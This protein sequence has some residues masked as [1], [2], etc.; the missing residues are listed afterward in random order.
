LA[1]NIAAAGRVAYNTTG[2]T[3]TTFREAIWWAIVTTTVG[4]GDYTPVAAERL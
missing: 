1:D 2:A 3:I 4:Y